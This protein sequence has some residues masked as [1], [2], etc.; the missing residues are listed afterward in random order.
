MSVFLFCKKLAFV[1]KNS[2][3]TQSNSVRAPIEIFLVLFSVFVRWK[4]AISENASFKDYALGIRLPDWS[5]LAIIGKMTMTSHF[6]DM[7]LSSHFFDVVLFLLSRLLTD[8]SFM[9]ISSLVVELWQFSFISDWPV[10]E[11]QIY[12]C[13]SFF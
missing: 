6:A 10:T 2:I 7:M 13:L 11:N 5:N 9:S 8:P 1:C 3:F 4:V 12:P